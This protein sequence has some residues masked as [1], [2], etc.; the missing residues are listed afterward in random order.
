MITDKFRHEDIPHIISFFQ[1]HLPARALFYEPFLW[2]AINNPKT[3]VLQGLE[4]DGSL[5]GCLLANITLWNE[6]TVVNILALASTRSCKT[7]LF[8]LKEFAHKHG[9]TKIIGISPR[10]PKAFERIFGFKTLS[11]VVGLDISG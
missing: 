10:N 2:A 9:A 6:E 4:E 1:E 8:L 5:W 11:Y 3:L 7:E